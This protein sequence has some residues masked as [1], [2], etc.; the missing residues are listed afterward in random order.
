[1]WGEVGL[2]LCGADG[3]KVV[4][5]RGEGRMWGGLKWVLFKL[6]WGGTGCGYM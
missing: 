5:E 6:M 1:M 4:R 2:K 3:F